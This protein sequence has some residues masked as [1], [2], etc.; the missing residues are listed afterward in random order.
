MLRGL[1]WGELRHA[2]ATGQ[3][4]LLEGPPTELRQH[5]KKLAIDGKWEQLLHA[6][7]DA[8]SL[9]CSR[10]WLDMQ[11]LVVEGCAALGSKYDLIAK[12]IQ[13]ELRALLRDVP[14]LMNTTLLDDTPAAN[15]ETRTWLRRLSAE[16][17]D[18]GEEAVTDGA[19]P[20]EPVAEEAGVIGWK[21]S[22]V[23]PIQL[24]R[25]ALEGDNK[26]EALEILQKDVDRQ[27]SGRG[28]F[29]KKL[30]M[31]ELC[32]KND[33]EAIAQPILD[34][35][36]SA[37]DDYKLEAWEDRDVVA[38]ALLVITQAHE[39]VKDDAKEKK[40]FFKRICRLD[41]ARALEC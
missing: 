22:F 21:R 8:M 35:L 14:E 40:K 4:Q 24:A 41:P 18:T 27:R 34:E 13:C 31:A 36:L 1:R 19:E 17:E 39:G 7:E 38:R 20:P 16:P 32:V 2:I 25:E 6:A 10:G 23:D 3:L 30:Q 12:A 15:Q 26:L 11:R 5:I 37:I 33:M 28:R 9:P 29:L